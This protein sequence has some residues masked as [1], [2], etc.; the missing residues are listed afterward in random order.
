MAALVGGLSTASLQCEKLV[1]QIDESRSDALAPKLEFEQSTVERQSL[2]DI[3]DFERYMVETNRARFS[4]FSHGTL[5]QFR[6]EKFT[7][8]IMAQHHS[9]F[10]RA[11]RWA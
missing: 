10:H 4:C 6:E 9:E 3:T 7:R 8:K 2:L 5:L 1:A 11:A